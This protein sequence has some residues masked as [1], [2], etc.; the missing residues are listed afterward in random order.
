VVEVGVRPA[1]L[2]MSRQISNPF[3]FFKHLNKKTRN[4]NNTTK[5][6]KAK[7]EYMQKFA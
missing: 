6:V 3:L 4:K 7:I 1:D 5:G 2:G